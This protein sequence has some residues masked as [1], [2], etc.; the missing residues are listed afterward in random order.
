MLHWP[1][2]SWILDESWASSTQYLKFWCFN[3]EDGSQ[4]I[5]RQAAA[6][7]LDSHCV[8]HLDHHPR[9]CRLTCGHTPEEETV[10]DHCDRASLHL[11]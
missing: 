1:S 9:N 7:L 8:D 3:F 4:Q 6:V 2:W 11:P 5:L 10:Q